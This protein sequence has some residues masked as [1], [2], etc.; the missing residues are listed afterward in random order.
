MLF[1]SHDLGVVRHVS[2][3]VLVR[4]DGEVV[5]EGQVDDVFT[6]PAHP[7]TGALVAAVPRLL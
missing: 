2:D 4:K 3:R 5:E 1:I 6:R 7:Y